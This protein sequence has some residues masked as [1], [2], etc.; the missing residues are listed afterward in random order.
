MLVTWTFYIIND[1]AAVVDGLSSDTH[2][3]IVAEMG[4]GSCEGELLVSLSNVVM[5][6]GKKL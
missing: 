2:F 1:M 6:C 3:G 4:C 5:S